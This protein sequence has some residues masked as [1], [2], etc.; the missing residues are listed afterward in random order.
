MSNLLAQRKEIKR[1]EKDEERRRKEELEGE[2]ERGEEEKERAIIEFERVMMGLEGGVKQQL[3]EAVGDKDGVIEWKGDRGS[4]RKFELDEEEIL[5]NARAER[6]K[7]R[8]VL[9]EEKVSKHSCCPSV[10][11][12]TDLWLQS[13]KPTLPSFWVPSLTP[14][15][16]T[17][18]SLPKAAKLFPLCPSSSSS[19]AHPLSLK[20]LVSIKFTTSEATSSANPSTLVCP[21]CK[22]GLSNTLK[23]M[24][25]IPCGH[26]LCKPCAGKF[27]SPPKEPPDPHAK[28]ELDTNVTCYV[29]EADLSGKVASKIDSEVSK[30]TSKDIVKSGLVQINSE[31]TG[32]AGGGKNMAKRDG[33]AF[34]C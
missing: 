23:A 18:N 5:K 27:M 4:K 11:G 28:S 2:M 12:L 14:S 20:S 13:S 33:V 24:L 16:K 3:G 17:T 34:Q 10:I 26:V 1:L 22:K 7:A 19:I 6:A 29:C 31:G 8:K 30:G 9:D 21:A 15:S 25:T 32:F